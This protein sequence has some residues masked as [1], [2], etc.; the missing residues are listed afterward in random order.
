MYLALLVVF[1]VSLANYVWGDRLMMKA[2]GLLLRDQN[3][4]AATSIVRIEKV[5]VRPGQKVSAG[6]ILF[7][8][9]SLEIIERLTD[10]SI[11]NAQIV[12]RTS[13]LEALRMLVTELLP[14]AQEKYER[15]AQAI[16]NL[17]ELKEQG[18]LPSA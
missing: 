5:N 17:E 16:E 18:L 10:Y 2:D 6:D 3:M 13:A 11:R 8:V 1:G 15:S 14:L 9:G 7:E 12:E 4:I